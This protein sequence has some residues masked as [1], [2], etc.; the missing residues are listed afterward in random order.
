MGPIAEKPSGAVP[1]RPN[2]HSRP[3]FRTALDRLV[4]AFEKPRFATA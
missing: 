2:H 3:T 4:T 1:T